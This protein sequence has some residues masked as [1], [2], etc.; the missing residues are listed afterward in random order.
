MDLDDVE[1]NG[2]EVDIWKG[3]TKSTLHQLLG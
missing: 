1:L 2:V 3:T